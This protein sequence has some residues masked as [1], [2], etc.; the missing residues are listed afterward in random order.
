M[1]KLPATDKVLPKAGLKEI[2]ELSPLLGFSPTNLAMKNYQRFEEQIFLECQCRAITL[3]AFHNT[4]VL[5]YLSHFHV[6]L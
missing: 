6:F 5:A 2:I 3:S 4:V 1:D